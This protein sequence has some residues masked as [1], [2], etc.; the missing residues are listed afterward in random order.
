MEMSPKQLRW[1]RTEA[2]DLDAT[3][4]VG[5]NGLTEAVAAEL[6]EQ[7]EKR[8]LVKVRL[9]AAVRQEKS[10]KEVAAELAARLGASI[11][12]VKGNTVVLYRE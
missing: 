4:S 2:H 10:R 6:D 9:L 12:E 8:N 11:V 5:K 3:I 1:L 7:L